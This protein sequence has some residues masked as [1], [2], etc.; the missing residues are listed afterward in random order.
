M[1]TEDI[2]SWFSTILG[3]G[4]KAS[5][6]VLFYQ[7]AVGNKN[8]EIVPEMLIILNV[9]SAELWF[10]YW[11]RI[12]TKLAPIVS[13]SVSLVLGLIF[14]FIYLF[15]FSSKKCSK[16]FIYLILE[17]LTVALLYHSLNFL[18]LKF[19]GLIANI[20]NILNFISPAQRIV[21]VCKEKNYS[22]IPIVTTVLGCISSFG[23]LVFGILIK[24]YNVIIPN[25]ISVLIALFNTLIWCYFYCS[26]RQKKEKKDKENE[27]EMIETNRGDDEEMKEI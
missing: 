20:V 27:E 12:G 14:S 5:P 24:D 26:S 16:F 6:I 2:A 22:L 4:L 13:S 19:V 11:I 1:K 23:W 3:F 25:S 17:V 9:L 21:R 8:I 10:S 7:I 18:E 15:Y